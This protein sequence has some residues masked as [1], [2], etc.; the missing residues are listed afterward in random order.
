MLTS[1]MKLALA[2]A[3]VYCYTNKL[4]KWKGKDLTAMEILNKQSI[5]ASLRLVRKRIHGLLEK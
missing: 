3:E 5:Q 1:E 2:R 4:R